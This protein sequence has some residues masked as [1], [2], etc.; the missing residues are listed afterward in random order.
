LQ[1]SLPERTP[2]VFT[3]A[4]FLSAFRLIMPDAEALATAAEWGDTDHSR[5]SAGVA[6]GDPRGGFRPETSTRL[7]EDTLILLS[8]VSPELQEKVNNYF[9]FLGATPRAGSAKAKHLAQRR[10]QIEEL[11]ARHRGNRQE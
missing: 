10:A 1:P 7:T 5:E 11:I 8:L 3:Q 2:P 6:D 9:A 4:D